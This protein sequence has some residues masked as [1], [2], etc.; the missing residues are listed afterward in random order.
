MDASNP[1]DPLVIIV[2]LKKASGKARSGQ[3]LLNTL[4]IVRKAGFRRAMSFSGSP[5]EFQRLLQFLRFDNFINSLRPI[6]K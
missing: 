2:E 6:S 3:Q 1:A 5:T 4:E